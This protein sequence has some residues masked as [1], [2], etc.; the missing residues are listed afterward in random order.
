LLEDLNKL[1]WIGFDHEYV[2][3]FIEWG[4]GIASEAGVGTGSRGLAS[5]LLEDFEKLR[6]VGFGPEIVEIFT[7]CK[8]LCLNKF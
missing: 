7:G 4:A 6:W 8:A 1:L 2:D 3:S 5:V